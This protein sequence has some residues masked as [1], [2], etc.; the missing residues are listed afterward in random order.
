M[1]IRASDILFGAV[2]IVGAYLIG[3]G[4]A[5]LYFDYPMDLGGVMNRD[6]LLFV[7]VGVIGVL[8]ADLQHAKMS[9][10]ERCAEAE[11]RIQVMQ[12]SVKALRGSLMSLTHRVFTIEKPP[13]N[14]TE[15]GLEPK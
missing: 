7:L 12:E 1:K 3:V 4:F 14:Q 6:G 10:R 9:L 8:W 2:W 5:I 11:D 13:V 15:T